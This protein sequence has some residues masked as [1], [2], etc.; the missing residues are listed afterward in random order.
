M[1]SG[2]QP[3]GADL[4][5]AA[6]GLPSPGPALLP[7]ATQPGP[8]THPH[9]T[10]QVDYQALTADVGTGQSKDSGE[11]Q[12]I[13]DGTEL[14]P[15]PATTEQRNNE[16]VCWHVW[17]WTEGRE[18][19][20]IV[21]ITSGHPQKQTLDAF[22][23][24]KGFNVCTLTEFEI[25][26]GMFEICWSPW[27]LVYFRVCLPSYFISLT[28]RQW[29]FSRNWSSLNATYFILLYVCMQLTTL[30]IPVILSIVSRHSKG[31]YSLRKR[32]AT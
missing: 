6:Q 14:T 17:E 25:P 4:G 28:R 29:S 20:Y 3:A 7:A 8:H 30:I 16:Q 11:G 5:E 12:R 9:P 1:A 2:A 15:F 32:S 26:S 13:V 18:L 31:L 21:D 10:P 19:M 22:L 27:D 23:K 24:N